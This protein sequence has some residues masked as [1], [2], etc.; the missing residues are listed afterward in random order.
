ML[1]HRELPGQ[2]S[3]EASG[4]RSSAVAIYHW[5]IVAMGYEELNVLRREMAG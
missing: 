1:R 3:C 2:E 4:M 5:P